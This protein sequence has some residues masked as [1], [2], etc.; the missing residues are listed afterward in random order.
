MDLCEI[1]SCSTKHNGNFKHLTLQIQDTPLHEAARGGHLEV[2]NSLLQAS[3]DVHS[4]NEV[5]R[6]VKY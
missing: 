2:C 6:H 5:G 4:R 1:L 3:A